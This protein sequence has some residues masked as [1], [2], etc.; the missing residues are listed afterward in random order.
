VIAA[1]SGG[2]WEQFDHLSR[3]VD[4]IAATSVC[5]RKFDSFPIASK[6]DCKNR[7]AADLA[8]VRKEDTC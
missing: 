8:L 5:Y 4:V 1:L 2:Q 6:I 7:P 3:Y